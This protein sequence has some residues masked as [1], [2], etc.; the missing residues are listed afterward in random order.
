MASIKKFISKSPNFVKKLYYNL[1]PF[2]KRYGSEF[3]DTYDFLLHSLDFTPEQLK[4]Y[5]FSKLREVISNAY[6]NVPYYHKL[7]VDYGVSKYIQ[8]PSDI[9]KLPIL[10]KQLVKDNWKDLI[11]KKYMAIDVIVKCKYFGVKKSYT[12]KFKSSKEYLNFKNWITSARG[13]TN[14]SFLIKQ[15]VN[16]ELES[17]SKQKRDNSHRS[18]LE[19]KLINNSLDIKFNKF[20]YSLIYKN[21][22]VYI[23]KTNNIQ[24]RIKTHQLEGLKKFDRFSIVER[25]SEETDD[26]EVLKY[27]EKIIK[28]LKPIYNISHNK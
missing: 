5:Q 19:F 26:V 22:I 7:M 17:I 21:K 16:K 15:K 3:K 6:E 24:N 27:E 4:E 28:L 18:K 11:N 23:G 2:Y 9:S 20:V 14:F 13:Y 12:K 1:V 10:T 8:D 25:F